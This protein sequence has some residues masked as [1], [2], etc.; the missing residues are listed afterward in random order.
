MRTIRYFSYILI[1]LPLLLFIFC[2]EDNN[3]Y[4]E[5]ITL[6]D[7]SE[8][9]DGKNPSWFDNNTVGFSGICTLYHNDFYG[10]FTID[11]NGDNL[12][13]LD[14]GYRSLVGISPPSISP[15]GDKIVFSA[16]TPEYHDLCDIYIMPSEGGLPEKVPIEGE[17]FSNFHP[18]WSPDGEWIAFVRT[19]PETGKDALWK[20]RP[21][22]EDL[23]RLGP[24]AD[25]IGYPD[26]SPDGEWIVYVEGSY[27][28]DSYIS[29][30]MVD[31]TKKWNITEPKGRYETTPCVSPD[32]LWVCYASPDN[33]GKTELYIIP[34]LGGDAEKITYV[35]DKYSDTYGDCEP[36]WSPDGEWIVFHSQGRGGFLFKVKVPDEFTP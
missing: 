6:L 25:W 10:I 21:D 28:S 3:D 8:G 34:Y 22:G 20:M 5:V 16:S 1:L 24:D 18:D 17:G 12:T 32:G 27:P 9:V 14:M 19:D 23:E 36:D 33:Y 30:Q 4:P 13:V 15:S 31:G 11:E 35:E 2:G 7:Y 26:W 29:A